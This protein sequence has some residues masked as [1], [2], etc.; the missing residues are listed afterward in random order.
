M[1]ECL[2]DWQR[3][4]CIAVSVCFVCHICMINKF[5][6]LSFFVYLGLSSFSVRFSAR[7][8]LWSVQLLLL[9]LHCFYS[10]CC[11]CCCCAFNAAL[12]VTLIVGDAIYENYCKMMRT[13]TRNGRGTDVRRVRERLP[14][15]HCRADRTGTVVKNKHRQTVC[16]SAIFFKFSFV[17]YFLSLWFA[18]R[19]AHVWLLLSPSLLL[20]L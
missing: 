4:C 3:V 2:T 5:P 1:S 9:L 12:E 13:R 17:F 18:P 8:Y 10:L 15:L 11:C 20:L 19:L 7:F 14:P 6:L 16:C